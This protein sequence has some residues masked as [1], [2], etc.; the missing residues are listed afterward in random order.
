MPHFTNTWFEGQKRN[1]EALF[2]KLGVEQFQNVLEIGS[3]E[4]QSTL[5]MLHLFPRCHVTCVDT[6]DGG[7]QG[8]HQTEDY[9][10][11]KNRFDANVKAFQDRVTVMRLPSHKALPKLL[12]DNAQFDMIYVDG[13]HHSADV[14]LDAVLS[15]HLL[16]CGGILV[17][18]DYGWK[19]FH[20]SHLVHHNPKLAIDSFLCAFC[21]EIRVLHQGWQ[22]FVEKIRSR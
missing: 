2:S 10:A 12:V 13:S 5:G 7:G 9:D 20:D 18:D 17:F 8:V 16:R 19:K 4:G 1:W 11:V 6:W 15:F 14:I 22:V 3:Y 21:D